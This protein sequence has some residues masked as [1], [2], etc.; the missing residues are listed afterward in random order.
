MEPGEPAGAATAPYRHDIDI[1]P[2]MSGQPERDSLDGRR[3]ATRWIFRRAD[4]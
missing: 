2:G 4:L 1:S 3:P